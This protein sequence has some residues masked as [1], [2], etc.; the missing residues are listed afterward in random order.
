MAENIN[1]NYRTVDTRL[2]LHSKNELSDSVQN[3][4]NTQ[5]LLQYEETPLSLWSKLM[6]HMEN[7][8]G[9]QAFLI[10][11]TGLLEKVVRKK[12]GNM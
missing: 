6:C 9:F 4:W 1:F 8:L 12:V 7:K 11:C 3:V 10:D 2:F 5:S